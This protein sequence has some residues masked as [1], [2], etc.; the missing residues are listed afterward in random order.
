MS[1]EASQTQLSRLSDMQI[2][3][4]V[5]RSL[6]Y[7]DVLAHCRTEGETDVITHDV[8]QD[9][10]YRPDLVAYRVYG[11]PVMRWAVSLVADV[12][13]EAEPL[14]VGVT[15]RLPSAAWVRERIRHYM[16]GGGI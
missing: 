5:I 8:L 2:E 15:L 11:N 6:L 10:V 12:E 13:D 9:E 7:S 4:D 14:P 16:D 1:E 3:D